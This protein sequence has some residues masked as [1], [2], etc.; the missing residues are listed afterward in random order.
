[1]KDR[2]VQFIGN[3]ANL[4][5]KTHDTIPCES[6]VFKPSTTLENVGGNLCLN[7]TALYPVGTYE[8]GCLRE[9]IESLTSVDVGLSR[10]NLD[11]VFFVYPVGMAA[12]DIR[13]EIAEMVWSL[14]KNEVPTFL[15]RFP[16]RVFGAN[17]PNLSMFVEALSDPQNIQDIEYLCGLD[18]SIL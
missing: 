17:E 8:R 12:L 6:L 2:K 1:M 5:W 4:Y 3:H 16:E 10:K 7:Q 13:K 14:K 11:A 18:Q 9:Q 15:I